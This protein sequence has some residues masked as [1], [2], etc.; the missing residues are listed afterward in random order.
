MN[1]NRVVVFM[2][3]RGIWSVCRRWSGE[4]QKN[5][6]RSNQKKLC[7]MTQT[8]QL[9]TWLINLPKHCLRQPRK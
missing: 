1:N 9:S 6:E 8:K 7:L 5:K 3:V 4:E 2:G